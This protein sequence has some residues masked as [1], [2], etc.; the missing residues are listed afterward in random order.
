MEKTLQE[1]AELVGGLLTGDGTIKISGLSNIP[2]SREGDLTFA[3]PPHIEEAKTSK[4]S[5]VLI[6][7]D[8]Q[9]FPK[10]AIKVADPRATFAML[11][12]KFTPKIEIQKGS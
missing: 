8:T 1:V 7:I 5:A 11:L 12:E 9:D 6:P 4:A 2:M 10:P 3:V